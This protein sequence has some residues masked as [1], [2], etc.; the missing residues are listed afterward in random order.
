MPAPLIAL[1]A[2]SSFNKAM[3]K[4]DTKSL[5]G[6]LSINVETNISS[7]SKALDAFGKDQIPF[8]TSGALNDTAFIVRKTVVEDTYPKAFTVRNKRFIGTPP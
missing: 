8:A 4:Q 5:L 3:A 1:K 7:L 6:G 2:A